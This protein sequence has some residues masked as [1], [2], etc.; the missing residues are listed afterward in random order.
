MEA[1]GEVAPWVSQWANTQRE[2]ERASGAPSGVVGDSLLPSENH[3]AIPCIER[4]PRAV[5]VGSRGDGIGA[6]SSGR[7]LA[8]GST[9]DE[10]TRYMT[11]S[12]IDCWGVLEMAS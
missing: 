10:G 2:R 1:E 4:A 12:F 5:D 9:R 8:P 3:E 11:G 6:R 7:E